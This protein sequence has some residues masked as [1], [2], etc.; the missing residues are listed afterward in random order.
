[1]SYTPNINEPRV[2]KRIK[3]ALGFV[4]ACMSDTKSHPW[5]TRYISKF[6]GR[7][8]ENLGNWLRNKLLIC[9]ND[10]W[11]KDDKI[12]KEY[13]KNKTGYDELVSLIKQSTTYPIV[14]QVQNVLITD[15]VK[16]EYKQE[17]TNKNFNYKDKSNRYWHDLQRVKRDYKKIVFVDSGL[18]YQ[19]DIQCC[20]PTLIHQYSQMLPEPMDLYLKNIQSYIK[21]RKSIRIKLA[22][23]TDIPEDMAKEI[24]NALLMGAKLGNVP[25]SAIYQLLDG[26]IS[27]IEYLKQDPFIIKYKEELKIIWNYIKPTL[28]KT[29]IKNKN[30]KEITKPISSKQK[31]GVYFELERQVLD[32]VKDY[33]KQTGNQYFLEHDGW[34]CTNQINQQE[35]VEYIKNSTGFDIQLDLEVLN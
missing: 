5:S 3:T 18:T 33:L 35:L 9:T 34:V 12:C 29:T 2:Q 22:N 15:W 10:R 24:I 14:R 13:I 26:D 32:S 7:T 16:N 25:K 31:A 23:D 27:R 1:M 21:D 19:Y 28:R 8:N 30:G 11:S 4:G 17:L 6:V 20:A